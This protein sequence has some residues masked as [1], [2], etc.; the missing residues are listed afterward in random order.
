MLFVGFL[1]SYHLTIQNLMLIDCFLF[2]PQFFFFFLSFS[3][4]DLLYP[5][6]I[7]KYSLMSLS[8][9]LSEAPCGIL[10]VCVLQAVTEKSHQGEF[11][12][13]FPFAH[14]HPDILKNTFIKYAFVRFE[15]YQSRFVER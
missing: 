15:S 1:K 12:Y 5:L 6:G 4:L 11:S 3:S 13:T 9:Y 2:I 8:H 14:L 7:L 10:I